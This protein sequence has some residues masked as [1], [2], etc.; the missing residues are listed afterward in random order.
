M[1]NEVQGPGSDNGTVATGLGGDNGPPGDGGSQA[2]E[3]RTSPHPGDM[4]S[5]GE[6]DKRTLATAIEPETDDKKSRAGGQ[7]SARGQSFD[8]QMKPEPEVVDVRWKVAAYL[9]V[10]LQSQCH[11][12]YLSRIKLLGF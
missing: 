10:C 9:E 1:K 4:G 12:F 8:E 7:A 3:G 6:Q 11:H 5:T 2:R